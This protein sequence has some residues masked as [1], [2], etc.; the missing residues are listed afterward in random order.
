MVL[1]WFGLPIGGQGQAAGRPAGQ[2]PAHRVGRRRAK[3]GLRRRWRL[4]KNVRR[5]APGALYRPADSV[6]TPAKPSC[7]V[8]RLWRPPAAGA[9]PGRRPAG[10]GR[11]G[12]P[13]AGCVRLVPGAVTHR[14]LSVS[15]ST[16]PVG[17]RAWLRSC[18]SR[19]HTLLPAGSSGNIFLAVFTLHATSLRQLSP[20]MPP[21][22]QRRWLGSP[23]RW[24]RARH[25]RRLAARRAPGPCG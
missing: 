11:A 16:G 4:E 9:P 1:G 13:V 14:Q 10:S 17:G 21:V 24:P 19:G 20:P 18:R 12:P 7:N 2:F 15:V 6:G 8:D 22:P 5:P 25:C 23:R 3:P